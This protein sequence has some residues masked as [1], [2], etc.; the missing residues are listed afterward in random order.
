M[1]AL[2]F[3]KKHC[4]SEHESARMVVDNPS[5]LYGGSLR[6]TEAVIRFLEAHL[7]TEEIKHVLMEAPTCLAGDSSGNTAAVIQFLEGK[8]NL[9]SSEDTT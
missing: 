2:D 7:S 5:L 4:G 3:V 8:F 6:A 1:A 9:S